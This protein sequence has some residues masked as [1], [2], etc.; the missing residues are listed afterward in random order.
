MKGGG[1][2]ALCRR[3]ARA[4]LSK[5]LAGASCRNDESRIAKPPASHP[6]TTKHSARRRQSGGIKQAAA[7][8]IRTGADSRRIASQTNLRLGTVRLLPERQSPWP[9]AHPHRQHRSNAPPSSMSLVREVAPVRRASHGVPRYADIA[10]SP[11][12]QR[13]AIGCA[14]GRQTR[15]ERSLTA[16]A[17]TSPFAGKGRSPVTG[18]AACEISPL[19]LIDWP[20]YVRPSYAARIAPAAR[21][22]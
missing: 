16:R 4:C 9:T 1:K 18:Q 7:F 11:A 2:V 21:C 12:P 5:A 20:P 19:R 6:T 13:A 17:T 14:C 15:A 22:R 10:S 8:P 3:V